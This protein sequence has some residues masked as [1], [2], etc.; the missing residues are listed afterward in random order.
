MKELLSL[1]AHL[2]PDLLAAVVDLIR[3]VVQSDDPKRTAE[4][5]A[6][7]IAAREASEV[8]ARRALGGKHG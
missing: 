6:K 1:I 2:P 4:R 7:M 3:A 5:H 8:V